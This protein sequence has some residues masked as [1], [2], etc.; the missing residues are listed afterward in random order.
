M[1]VPL[2]LCVLCILLLAACGGS[3]TNDSP[4]VQEPTTVTTDVV[5]SDNNP[6]ALNVPDGFDCKM[7]RDIT[8][9]LQVL[10]HNHPNIFG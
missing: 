10:D 8:V 6:D 3:S 9:G 1:K 2:I 5:I 7:H 4:S